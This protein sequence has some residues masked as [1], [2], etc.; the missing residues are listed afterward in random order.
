MCN[1]TEVDVHGE[2]LTKQIVGVS[3]L[4]HRLADI[5]C[6]LDELTPLS[7]GMPKEAMIPWSKA[8]TGLNE[9]YDDLVALDGWLA[10]LMDDGREQGGAS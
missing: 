1:P 10:G 7:V 3:L 5:Q 2:E 9:A 6:E 8:V 4:R